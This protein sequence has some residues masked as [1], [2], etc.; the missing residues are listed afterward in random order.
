MK[1]HLSRTMTGSTLELAPEFVR[2]SNLATRGSRRNVTLLDAAH[3][4]T[5]TETAENRQNLNLEVSL[6]K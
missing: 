1:F 6:G 2:R 5:S 4:G 3:P